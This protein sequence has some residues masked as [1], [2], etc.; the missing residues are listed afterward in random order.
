MRVRRR[1]RDEVVLWSKRFAISCRRSANLEMP[2]KESWQSEKPTLLVTPPLLLQPVTPLLQPVTLLLQP[3]TLLLQPVTLLPLPV[4]LLPNVKQ[5][6]SLQSPLLQPPQVVVKL[7][8]L[9]ELSLPP[10]LVVVKLPP[11]VVKQ[12]SLVELSLPPPSRLPPHLVVVKLPSLVGLSLPPPS[13]PN[14]KQMQSLQ[15]PLLQPQLFLLVV[16]LPLFLLVVKLPLFLLVVKLPSL[17]GLSL[18][19]VKQM[20]SLQ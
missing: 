8:S 1:C 9:V 15:S 13:L 18:P 5:M 10:H 2:R 11:L 20:Q 4:I 19:N 17:V 3:L 7:P 12:P 14:V 16:K 6:Q